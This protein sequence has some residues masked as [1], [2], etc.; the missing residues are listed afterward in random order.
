KKRLVMIAGVREN[1]LLVVEGLK[2]GERV[3]VAGVSFLRDGQRVK[4]L[5]DNK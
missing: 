1:S 2:T 3:A 5:P 4:L